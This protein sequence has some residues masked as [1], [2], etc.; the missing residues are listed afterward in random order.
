MLL[1]AFAVAAVVPV[2]VPS[3]AASDVAAL[4]VPS[5]SRYTV[6]LSCLLSVL[7]RRFGLASGGSA[8]ELVVGR[9]GEVGRALHEAVVA[10]S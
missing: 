10:A 7:L 5:L 8:L 4:L 3:A 1:A 9:V 2:V 6:G